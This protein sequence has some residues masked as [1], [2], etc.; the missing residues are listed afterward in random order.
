MNESGAHKELPY[1]MRVDDMARCVVRH[2]TRSGAACRA[3]LVTN[4]NCRVSKE[5]TP[6]ADA[7]TGTR[8]SDKG[9]YASPN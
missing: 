1:G 2:L 9:L 5:E 6:Q 4:A 7:A 3:V 8:E